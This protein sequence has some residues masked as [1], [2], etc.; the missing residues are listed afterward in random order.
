MTKQI[1]VI[2]THGVFRPAEPLEEEFAEGQRLTLILPETGAE[3]EPWVEDE[4]VRTWCAEQAGEQV[5]SL[6]EVRQMLATI[7]GAMAD[8][9]I[10]ERDERF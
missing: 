4:A 1:E 6:E 10:A 5:P 3:H 2:Y 9:V 7:P 8:V